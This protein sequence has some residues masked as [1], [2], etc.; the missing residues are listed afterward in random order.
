MFDDVIEDVLA[1]GD[2]GDEADGC[3]VRGPVGECNY[4]FL[5]ASA[6][7]TIIN[8]LLR[9]EYPLTRGA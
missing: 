9:I 3:R 4:L 2:I 5:D 7:A 8:K 1:R 6:S